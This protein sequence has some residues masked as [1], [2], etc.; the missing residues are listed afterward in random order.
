[1]LSSSSHSFHPAPSRYDYTDISS[2]PR[3][4]L[5]RLSTA[6]NTL[7]LVGS[8]QPDPFSPSHVPDVSLSNPSASYASPNKRRRVTAGVTGNADEDQDEDE[9]MADAAWGARSDSEPAF[10]APGPSAA[11]ETAPNTSTWS[12]PPPPSAADD[13]NGAS[14]SVWAAV[15]PIPDTPA[16]SPEKTRSKSKS[17]SK[18]KSSKVALPVPS[19]SEADSD[20]EGVAETMLKQR[21]EARQVEEQEQLVAAAELEQETKERKERK[22]KRKSKGGEAADAS[23]SADVD[24][25]ENNQEKPKKKKKKKVPKEESA[26]D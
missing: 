12:V 11:A 18:S 3:F 25:E 21:E 23:A 24:V 16:V 20:D 13:L 26:D 1:M 17:K 14:A 5:Y 4:I 7:T 9:D 2:F 19:D 10:S 15:T 22:K 6:N 8:L